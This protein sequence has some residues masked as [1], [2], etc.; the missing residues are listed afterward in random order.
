MDQDKESIRK[1]LGDNM[2]NEIYLHLFKRR[3]QNSVD[4]QQLFEELK[5]MVGND[6]KMFTEIFKLDGIVTKELINEN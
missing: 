1:K 2:F 6:K 3:S 4:E 5:E